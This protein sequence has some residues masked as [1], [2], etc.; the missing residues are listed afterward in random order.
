MD[1]TFPLIEKQA[2]YDKKDEGNNNKVFHDIMISKLKPNTIDGLKKIE[3]PMKGVK[4]GWHDSLKKR[5]K[6]PDWT[7]IND[8]TYGL[9]AI[10]KNTKYPQILV[11]VFLKTL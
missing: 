7:I 9:D 5:E 3:P 11:K 4:F 10:V 8:P 1:L 2:F 6:N